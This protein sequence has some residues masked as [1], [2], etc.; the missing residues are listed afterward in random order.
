MRSFWLRK[1]EKERGKEKPDDNL[2]T[3]QPK[4][5][6]VGS[7]KPLETSKRSECLPSLSLSLFTCCLWLWLWLWQIWS[8][9]L[10]RERCFYIEIEEETINVSNSNLDSLL[11]KKKRCWCPFFF[12]LFLLINADALLFSGSA[13]FLEIPF[14][15]PFLLVIRR[16]Q[17]YYYGIIVL[18]KKKKKVLLLLLMLL[19]FFKFLICPFLSVKFYYQI[20]L[21]ITCMCIVLY[22]TIFYHPFQKKKKI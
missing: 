13:I 10:Q 21:T 17:F 8:F 3:E 5:Q 9:R 6:E 15:H 19:F 16:L 12:F 20:L 2:R 14:V 7:E 18:L 11:K 22:Y 4:H 1:I